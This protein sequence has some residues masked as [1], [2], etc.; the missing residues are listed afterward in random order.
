VLTS[1]IYIWVVPSSNLG[2]DSNALQKSSVVLLFQRCCMFSL[3]AVKGNVLCISDYI[4]SA[5]VFHL[6][7][8][9]LQIL[10][11][12]PSRL[13]AGLEEASSHSG[14]C[15]GTPVLRIRVK[16]LKQQ[17][18]VRIVSDH[19]LD[20]RVRSPTEAEDFPSNL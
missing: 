10:F 6:L 17:M 5:N 15:G 19:G 13:L 4:S 2:R 1:L 14:G 9:T 20:R 7:L 3:S 8:E 16:W 18:T 12:E 11:R